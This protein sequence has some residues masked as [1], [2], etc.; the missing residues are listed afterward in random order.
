MIMSYVLIAS[1]FEVGTRWGYYMDFGYQK[2]K[3]E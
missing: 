3:F 2:V 1:T